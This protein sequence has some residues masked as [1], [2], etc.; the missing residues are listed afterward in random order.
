M[1]LLLTIIQPDGFLHY[2]PIK[3]LKP[4]LRLCDLTLTSLPHPP[5]GHLLQREKE[6]LPVKEFIK[7]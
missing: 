1:D 5:F 4:L 3:Y 7:F 2:C 6:P